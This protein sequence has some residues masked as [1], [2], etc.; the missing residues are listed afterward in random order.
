MKRD[1]TII[2]M[3]AY[4]LVPLNGGDF[5]VIDTEDAHIAAGHHWSRLES[6][7]TTY[8]RRTIRIDGKQKTLLLHRE[9]LGV[10]AGV[11]IDHRSGD[12][13]D[14]RKGN[15]RPA[16]KQQNN[17]NK[18]IKSNSATGVKGV[19]KHSLC[20]KFVAEIKPP[21]GKRIYLGLFSSI[22]DAAAAYAKASAQHH[23]EFGRIA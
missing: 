4:A 1:T 3:G 10:S 8:A 5:A 19:R 12:G 11:L 15:L 13:L 17:T 20:N 9:V 23:G 16:T 7:K 22:K 18:R 6:N 14:C 2:L 21:N